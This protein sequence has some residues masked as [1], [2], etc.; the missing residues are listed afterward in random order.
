MHHHRRTIRLAGYDYR[1]AG[2]YFITICTHQRTHLFADPML[3]HI[4]EQQWAALA[5]AGERGQH[6]GRVKID[7]F[8]VM[9]DHIHG[10]IVITDRDDPMEINGDTGDGTPPGRAQQ[11]MDGGVSPGG[12]GA[13]A[14]LHPTTPAAAS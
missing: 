11:P 4:A 9:P 10:I 14:P 2:V 12:P 3:R 5:H 7:A 8:V 13:A 1:Q 6:K